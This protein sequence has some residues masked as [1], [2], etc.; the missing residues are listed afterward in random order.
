LI[1]LVVSRFANSSAT[2]ANASVVARLTV[3]GQQVRRAVNTGA[4]L[5][6]KVFLRL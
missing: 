3:S 1:A 6:S 2:P 4:T 5:A